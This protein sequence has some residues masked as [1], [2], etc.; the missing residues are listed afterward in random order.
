MTKLGLSLGLSLSA[1]AAKKSRVTNSVSLIPTNSLSAWLKGDSGVN[2]LSYSYASQIIITGTSY[3]NFNGTYTADSTPSY[4]NEYEN[5]LD[6]Y[7]FSG[8]ATSFL[9]WNSSESRYEMYA[10]GSGNTGGF[11]SGDGITWGPIESYISTIDVGGFTGIYE[12]ANGLYNATNP[13]S[14]RWNHQYGGFFI[15]SDTLWTSD[16]IPIA[17]NSN[18]YVGAWTPTS[19][20]SSVTLSGAGTTAVNGVYT[21]SDTEFNTE[22]V[23]FSASGGRGLFWNGDEWATSDFEYLGGL[24]NWNVYQGDPDAPSASIGSSERSIG[25]VTSSTI[26]RPSGSISG[27]V[28]N[29][30]VNTQLVTNWLDQSGNSRNAS[31][32]SG[33]AV[34]ATIG[35][36]SFV[37]FAGYTNLG[38]PAIWDG[39]PY[40]GTI[41][42]VGR[43]GASSSGGTAVL[44]ANENEGSEFVLSRGIS[45][46]NAFSLT[47]DSATFL[48]STTNVNNNTNYIIGATFSGSSASLYL[49]GAS[50]GTGSFGNS[51]GVNT[52]RIGGGNESSYIAEIIVYTRVLN[53]TERQQVESY[54]SSKYG[55]A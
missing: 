6:S 34:A 50:V 29:T 19:Y 51:T 44:L 28:T 16:E 26:S 2:K 12:D 54:L 38:F 10:I 46:T 33:W 23:S 55:I 41:F 52:S 47:G 39:A 8:P 17:T 15:E 53:T 40:T 35:G 4:G 13:P 25:S 24:E 3:P 36:K 30:T 14:S 27:S 43:F 1:L 18:G 42:V 37:T 32:N 22:L 5:I 11:G 20:I 49:N 9:S 31:R 48:N 7:T 45:S 21:R